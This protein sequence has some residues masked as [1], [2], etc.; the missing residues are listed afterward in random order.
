M[1]FEHYELLKNNNNEETQW[2]KASANLSL[3]LNTYNLLAQV[4]WSR[5][6]RMKE[7]YADPEPQ[8]TD[9]CSRRTHGLVNI[10][11]F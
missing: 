3:K 11:F 2:V 1:H 10:Q 7:P 8:I 5:S 4:T 9:P 6:I